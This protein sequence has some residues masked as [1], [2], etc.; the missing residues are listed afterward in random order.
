MVPV[1]FNK[2]VYGDNELKELEFVIDKRLDDE[3][4]YEINGYDKDGR[5]LFNG[6]ARGKH[7]YPMFADDFKNRIRQCLSEGV[8]PLVEIKEPSIQ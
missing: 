4:V 3:R 7:F 1:Y 2:V 5:F 8:S 6:K